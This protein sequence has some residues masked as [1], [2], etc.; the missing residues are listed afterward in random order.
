MVLTLQQRLA[1]KL[2]NTVFGSDD[3][4]LLPPWQLR[5]AEGDHSSIRNAEL[6][7]IQSMLEDLDALATG[8]KR[9]NSRG[10]L[11][12]VEVDELA[13]HVRLNPLIEKAGI[14]PLDYLRVPSISSALESVRREVGI[15]ALR[16]SL[17]VRRIGLRADLLA[18]TLPVESLSERPVDADWLLRWQENAGRAV[19]KDFQ[20]MWAR[21]LV[22]EVR[23]PGTHCL[24][25]Q[26]F[27]ASISRADMT[28]IR[29]MAPL[30][31]Q[32]F[33][34]L[35]ASNYFNNDIHDPMFAQM[36]D[37]GLLESEKEL[38]RLRSVTEKG[39]RAVLRCHDKA[40]YIEGEGREL[41][42]SAHRFTALGRRVVSVLGGASNAG[43]L[44]ALG[45]A[46]KKRNYR[47][48]IGD[49]RGQSDG[50]GFFSEKMSL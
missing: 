32:G 8:K 11:L 38:V 4:A 16:H 33:I 44:F 31:L 50:K 47:V 24:R 23:Q 10:E 48:D 20:D 43:Y 12:E 26:A 45:N 30:D 5:Q 36:A 39:F 29:F 21:V 41:A 40:I 6:T 34:C 18:E 27:L 1:D 7:A 19:A 17:N 35:E 25:T 14:D 37:M 9:I 28:V 2:W 46:L 3:S 13:T 22:D 49:W 15:R 42:V